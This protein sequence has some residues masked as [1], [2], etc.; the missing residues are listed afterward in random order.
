MLMWEALRQATDEELERDPTV[1]SA[2]GRV[3]G[4]LTPRALF[5]DL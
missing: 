5:G 3:R 2:T 4:A 1:R